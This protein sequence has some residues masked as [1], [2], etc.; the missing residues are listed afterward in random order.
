MLGK[1]SMKHWPELQVKMQGPC[2]WVQ[3][4]V[5]TED[6]VFLALDS[7]QQRLNPQLPS[8]HQLLT[9]HLSPQN[10]H[11][12]E[13]QGAIFL[14]LLFFHHRNSPHHTGSPLGIGSPVGRRTVRPT[15]LYLSNSSKASTTP[16]RISLRRSPGLRP[17]TQP[18]SLHASPRDR[19]ASDI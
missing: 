9:A 19:Y 7:L 15:S 3:G 5:R 4:S 8:R 10:C 14:L 17:A 16:M 12:T 2:R 13:L 1:L 6:E 18:T 11:L